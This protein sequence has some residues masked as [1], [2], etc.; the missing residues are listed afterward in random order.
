MP[1]SKAHKVLTSEQ[2]ETLKQWIA[3]GAEY[4]IHWAFVPPKKSAVPAG[5]HPVDHFVNQRLAKEGLAPSPPANPEAL[6][7]RLFLDLTGLPPAPKDI[8]AFLADTSTDHWRKNGHMS[9]E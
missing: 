8:D 2:I 7:R 1:P 5:V 6:M 3:G 4:Q 9:Q